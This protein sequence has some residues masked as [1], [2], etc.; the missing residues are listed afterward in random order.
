MAECSKCGDQTSM[1]FTCKFCEQPY[2]STH[3]LPENH[4]CD[5]LENYKE[6]SHDEGKIGYDAIKENNREV[7]VETRNTGRSFSLPS[8][9]NVL[10]RNIP[11]TF[12]LIGIMFFTY[13][14]QVSIPWFSEFFSLDAHR[15]VQDFEVWRIV[16]SMF[17]HGRFGHLLVNSVVLFS[18]GPMAERMLGTKR[19]LAVLFAAGIT[20]SIG[21][22]AWSIL[23]QNT[24]PAVGFSGA[25][26]GMVTLLAV[27][28][29]E[30][31]VLLFFFLPLS[32]RSALAV[33]VVA[34][35]VN[36]V[37]QLIGMPLPLLS[38]FASAGHLSGFLAGLFLAHRWKDRFG[39]R[40]RRM[41]Q[42]GTPFGRRVRRF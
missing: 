29:P 13:V 36:L 24:V 8:L 14:L 28:R 33:L 2:C 19:F 20:S 12:V 34:D 30:I 7:E 11:V 10:P 31:R 42:I 6:Q 17:L 37:T 25:L 41:M 21:F 1:P 5:G 35:T 16:S 38:L 32:I 18:F 4:D 27:L 9:G 39:G 26:Y 15:V 40:S 23:I 22:T 3:R